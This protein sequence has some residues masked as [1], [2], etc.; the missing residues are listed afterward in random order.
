MPNQA[1]PTPNCPVCAP[2]S[3]AST[4][5]SS[6]WCGAASRSNDG[7]GSSGSGRARPRVTHAHD[8]SVIRRYAAELGEDG[9]ALALVLLRLR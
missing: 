2:T 7:S 9:T 6:P 5:R 8:M 1:P 3:T 4:P